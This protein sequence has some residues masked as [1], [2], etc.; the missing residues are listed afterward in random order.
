MNNERSTATSRVRDGVYHRDISLPASVLGTF[1]GKFVPEY[2]SH[3][4]RACFNDR[5]GLIELPRLLEVVVSSIVEIEVRSGVAVKA[6]IRIAHDAAHDLVL[7]LCRPYAGY[8]HVKTVWLNEK[9][10][11]HKTLNHSQYQR[12]A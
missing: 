12:A 9:A 8:S 3:A 5:Y 2:S 1:T 7:V 11:C 6:V 4:R 10:D